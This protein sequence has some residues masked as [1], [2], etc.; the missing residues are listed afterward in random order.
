MVAA[1]DDPGPLYTRALIAALAITIAI[2]V[3]TY[4]LQAV[5]PFHA[6]ALGASGTQVGFL[7]SM[8]AGVAM[9]LRPAVGGWV[10]R[11]GV[12]VVLVPGVA[13]L[14]L[15]SLAFHVAGTPATLIAL[16]AGIGL[17]NGLVSTAAGVLAAQATSPARRGEALG[18]Y[19]VA[20]SLAVAAAAPGG[21][22]LFRW[23]GIRPAYLVVTALAIAIAALTL[24][25]TPRGPSAAPAASARFRFWSRHALG[26]AGVMVLLT[27]GWSSIVG[28][29]PLHAVRHGLDGALPWFFG[30]YSGWLLL[31][32]ILLRGLSDQIGRARV[33][34]PAIGATALGFLLLALPIP[35]SA[36]SLL[37]AAFI[38]GTG[39][40]LTY[41]TMVALLVDRTPDRE[42]GLAMGTLSAS[43]DVGVVI[44]SALVGAV[45][46]R[47]SFGTGFGVGAAGACAALALFLSLERRHRGAP[48]YPR[49][50][51]GV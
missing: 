16:M 29:V 35:P 18:V 23:G 36:A 27:L 40:T 6:T 47:A 39:A 5:L 3:A 33:L 22:A 21:I 7:F 8:N 41:P 10:D 32:R 25:M 19:Y 17:S 38:H 45:I 37:A 14:T 13:V 30:I 46:E 26:P 31:C 15:T 51:A 44:G 50:A 9:F 12:R 4:L 34:V 49:P 42:R 2:H 28:F 1:S 20:T 11:Y 48:A 24:L 43:W